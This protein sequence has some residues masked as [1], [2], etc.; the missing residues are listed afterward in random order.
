MGHTSIKGSIYQY[1]KG[2]QIPQLRNLKPPIRPEVLRSQRF[3]SSPTGEYA[4]VAK[5]LRTL[6]FGRLDGLSQD[7]IADLGEIRLLPPLRG[8][9]HGR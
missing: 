9:F 3:A 8:F 6:S 2:S 1:E 5:S 4:L 7:K